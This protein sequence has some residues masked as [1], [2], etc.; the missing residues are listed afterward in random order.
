VDE[1]GM[2][3]P[4]TGFLSKRRPAS[5]KSRVTMRT[6]NVVNMTKLLDMFQCGGSGMQKPV[7]RVIEVA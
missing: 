7:F 3:S 2:V 4:K 6:V 1:V 5:R